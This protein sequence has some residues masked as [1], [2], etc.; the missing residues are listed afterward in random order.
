MAADLHDTLGHLL[1]LLVLHANALTVS[2][3]EAETRSAAE[4]MSGLGNAGLDEL[5]NILA[6]LDAP[7]GPASVRLGN[8]PADDPPET[9]VARAVE[10]GQRVELRREGEQPE[11]PPATAS[12]VSRVV[13]EGLTNARKHAPGSEVRVTVATDGD[14]VRVTIRNGPG[15]AEGS[16]TGSGRGIEAM[17]RRVGMLGGSCEH[18]AESGGGYAVQVILP[19][20]G[21]AR[22][23]FRDGT[24]TE[25][26]QQS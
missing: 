6:L 20:D 3:K 22:T 9:L 11:L 8:R 1:T 14:V 12:T 26:T 4:R 2:S 18:A 19:L 7:A 16:G 13:Q 24:W 10:A 15:T 25:P 17:R 23:D 5:R 21:A